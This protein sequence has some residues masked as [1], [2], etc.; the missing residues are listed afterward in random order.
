MS[1]VIGD[2]VF[3]LQR[4]AGYMNAMES[5]PGLSV[6]SRVIISVI[7]DGNGYQTEHYANYTQQEG[8]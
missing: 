2:F 5:C 8:G 1:R 3:R 7:S 6:M 4:E